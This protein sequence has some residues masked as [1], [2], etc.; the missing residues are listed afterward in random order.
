MFARAFDCY[1]ADKLAAEK[2]RNRYLT[3]HTEAYVF[4]EYGG[5]SIY[6]IPIGSEWARINQKFDAVIWDLK[7]PGVLHNGEEQIYISRSETV[8][9]VKS[10]EN[11]KVN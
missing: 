7:E 4:K 10:I 1:V 8:V 9:K 2:S 5:K 3:V 11:S 6:G